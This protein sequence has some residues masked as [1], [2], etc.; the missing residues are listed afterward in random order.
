[1]H[2]IIKHSSTGGYAILVITAESGVKTPITFYSYWNSVSAKLSSRQIPVGHSSTRL[3]PCELL[4]PH[5]GQSRPAWDLRSR[6]RA[7]GRLP[8]AKTPSIQGLRSGNTDFKWFAMTRRS[9]R[10]TGTCVIQWMENVWRARGG[11]DSERGP[12]RNLKRGRER[13]R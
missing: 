3:C 2:W 10:N 6:P 11:N 7:Q 9:Q 4:L 8:I 5:P 13:G 12:G 1:M